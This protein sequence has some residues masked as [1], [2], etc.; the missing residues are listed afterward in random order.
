MTSTGSIS[1]VYKVTTVNTVCSLTSALD[2]SRSSEPRFY[3]PLPSSYCRIFL[4][5]SVLQNPMDFLILT[6]HL[7]LHPVYFSSFLHCDETIL[8]H[9]TSDQHF[10]KSCRYFPVL[11]FP[12]SVLHHGYCGTF[13][14]HPLKPSTP[15]T[16][17]ASWFSSP[18][19]PSMT[20]S[21]LS[22]FQTRAF[23][24]VS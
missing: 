4:A 20:V 18:L 23:L 9:I 14:F 21:F 11:I 16:A 10:A 12:A 22:T 6:S 2:I 7:L 19:A 15:R 5:H 13:P 24:R 1:S 17:H 3:P 8:A